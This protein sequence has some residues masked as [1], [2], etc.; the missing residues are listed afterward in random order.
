MVSCFVSSWRGRPDSKN[1]QAPERLSPK[2]AAVL[3]CKRPADRAP[4]EEQIFEQLIRV[5]MFASIH[6]IAVEFRD[7]LQLRDEQGLRLWLR[8][9]TRCGILPLVR[10]ASGLHRDLPAA[11][12][13]AETGWSNGQ[14]EG[15]INRLKTIKR[16]MYGRAG[17]HSFGHGYC[18]TSP[19]Q[20]RRRLHRMC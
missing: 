17:L 18:P 3:L 15:Q 6:A 7:A 5:P 2:Q 8:D 1:A 20:I 9:T 14:V 10:F 4:T 19:R 16:Q 13:G 11:I 12:G